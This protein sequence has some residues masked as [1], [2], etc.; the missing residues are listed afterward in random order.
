VLVTDH[1]LPGMCGLEL[2]CT[3]RALQS[4]LPVLL[5]SGYAEAEGVARDFRAGPSRSTTPT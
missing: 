2:A 1:L 3:A 4:W 5:V